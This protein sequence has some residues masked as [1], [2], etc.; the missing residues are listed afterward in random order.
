MLASF[1]SLSPFL[2]AVELGLLEM[3]I[4][5]ERGDRE[6]ISLV[7]IRETPIGSLT[8]SL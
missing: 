1:S 3:P 2:L 8:F 6:K 5:S 7:G 4:N